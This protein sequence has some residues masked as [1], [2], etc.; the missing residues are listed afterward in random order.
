MNEIAVIKQLPVITEKIKEVGK[1][2]D[3]RLEKLD[4]DNLVCDENSKKEIKSLKVE[5]GKEFKEFENQRKEIKN[6]IMEPYEAFNKTYEEEI[7]VKY[8][9]ADRTLG[10]KINEVE[11][12]LKH[13]KEVEV[14]EYFEELLESNNIDFIEFHQTNITITLTSTLKKLKEQAK[15]FVD[16]VVKELAIIDTQDYKDEILIEYK[17]DLN[18][19]KAVLDVVNRHKE[20]DELERIKESAKETVELEEKAIEKVDEVLQ[21]PTE[22]DVIEGQISIDE[23]EQEEVFETTFKV[24]GTGLQIRELKMFLENGGFEYESIT[25]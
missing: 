22:E 20:L 6:K 1:E 13:K 11:S 17:K 9:N 24:R 7:K 12:E 15:D 5:L 4:L 2:L 8:Q 23:F 10:D 21:A 3:D 18:L 14:K 25:E 19:N 16:N